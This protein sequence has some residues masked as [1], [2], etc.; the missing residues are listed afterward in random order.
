MKKT[1]VTLADVAAVAG[2]STRTVARVMSDPA[3][4]K[5]STAA[6]VNAIAAQLGYQSNELAR[7]L[8]GARSRTLGLLVPDIS[9]PFFALCCKAIE[10][11][12]RRRGYTIL[13]CDSDGMP[14]RQKEYVS[15]LVRRRVEGLVV[16]PVPG[17]DDDLH[18]DAL[19]GIPVVAIDRPSK[20]CNVQVVVTNREGTFEATA[21]LIGHGHQRIAFIGGVASVF[22]TKTRL[23]GYRDALKPLPGTELVRLGGVSF[24]HAERHMEELWSMEPGERPTAVVAGNSSLAAGVLHWAANNG[25]SVPR[26]LA[27]IGF[28][29]YDLLGILSPDLATIHQ[30]TRQL[31]EAA[32]D[33]I[34]DL[35]EGVEGP[36]RITLPTTFSPAPS[37]GCDTRIGQGA[38]RY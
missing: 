16:A 11:A 7:S 34:I 37:C 22:T 10:D 13:L 32:T 30:P 19:H 33:A 35:L 5:A 29:D 21:H 31:G 23:K 1:W 15:L 38:H 18:P 28:D 17:G 25:V 27:V 3:V 2:V 26:D 20:A 6:R 24:R 36:G 14:S 8:K 9:N 4:V 12:A